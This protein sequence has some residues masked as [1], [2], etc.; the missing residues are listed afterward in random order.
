MVNAGLGV[1]TEVC[2]LQN[3]FSSQILSLFGIYAD[4]ATIAIGQRRKRRAA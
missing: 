4:S 3:I 2:D 1:W